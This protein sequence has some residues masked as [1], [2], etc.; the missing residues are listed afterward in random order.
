MLPTVTVAI[1]AALRAII[2]THADDRNVTQ[3]VAAN[4]ALRDELVAAESTPDAQLTQYLTDP[5]LEGS[6]GGSPTVHIERNLNDRAAILAERLTALTGRTVAK[7]RVMQ[8]LLWHS[9]AP[10]PPDAVRVPLPPPRTLDSVTVPVSAALNTA[11]QEK[12]LDH[13]ITREVLIG[14]L[15]DAGF[16]AVDDDSDFT[17]LLT[18]DARVQA[19]DGRGSTTIRISRSHD[20]DLQRLADQSFDGIK[21][22][23]VQALLWRGLD[24]AE[25]PSATPPPDRTVL[26]DGTLYARVARAALDLKKQE[27]ERVPIQ[28]FVQDALEEKLEREERRRGRTRR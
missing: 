7:G 19:G 4:A 20:T 6:S 1:P 2:A 15:L 27:G 18:R 22:R 21:G 25:Q 17:A 11:L 26:I 14:R 24:Q 28:K 10:L 23:A 13:H 16:R 9:L 12:A 3:D 8:A 5:R